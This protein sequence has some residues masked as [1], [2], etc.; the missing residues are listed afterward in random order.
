MDKE[1]PLITIITPTYN[2]EECLK[3]CWDSLCQQSFT[4]FQWLIIDDGSNDKT[5]EVVK[6][7]IDNSEFQLEYHK[8]KNGGKHTALN[9]S[10]PYIKGKYVAILDSDDT[11]TPD[12]IEK[13]VGTWNK[14]E[15][16]PEVGQIIYLKGYNENDPI[17]YVNHPETVVDSLKEPRIAV[18]GRDCFDSYRTDLFIKYPFPEFENEK[19]IGEGSAFFYIELESKAVYTNDVIY[20]CDYREDGLTKAGRSMRLKNPNGGM[21]NSKVYMNPVLP[22]TTRI[23]KGILYGCYSKIAG[24]SFRSTIKENDYKVLTVL[25]YIP[26]AILA[27]IWEKKYSGGN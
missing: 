6:G 14:Y 8:K 11:L 16:N 18:T 21:Y 22:I 10:H 5:E 3:K 26:G 9:Y 25:T 13:L 12:A 15:S 20:I 19:F 2:R 27:Y 23:K 1:K 24:K 17:C 4:G 7:F